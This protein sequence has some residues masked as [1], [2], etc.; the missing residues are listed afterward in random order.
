MIETLVRPTTPEEISAEYGISE[1]LLN[2][3]S[4]TAEA[5]GASEAEKAAMGNII[6]RLAEHDP[7]TAEHSLRVGDYAALIARHIGADERLAFIAGTTHDTGKVEV[8][9]DVLNKPASQP[10]TDSDRQAVNHHSQAGYDILD[11]EYSDVFP[12]AIAKAAGTHHSLQTRNPNGIEGLELTPQE[13]KIMR[14]VAIADPYDASSTRNDAASLE[15]RGEDLRERVIADIRRI[16]PMET[17]L[18]PD[19]AGDIFDNLEHLRASNAPA[20][21]PHPAD[22]R[23]LLAA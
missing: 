9:T 19:L 15:R 3:S 20:K 8:P 12:P 2:V 6:V 17:G 23:E 1:H 4:A 16:L 11:A 14:I 22:E 5:V 21:Q 18:S 10:F 13:E 7:A